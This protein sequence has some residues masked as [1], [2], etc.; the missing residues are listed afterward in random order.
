MKKSL[1]I[2]IIATLLIN[3]LSLVNAQGGTIGVLPPE[4]LI[5]GYIVPRDLTWVVGSTTVSIEAGTTTFRGI[6]YTWPSD[7]GTST[8]V[9]STDGSSLLTWVAQTGGAGGGGTFWS[10]A[11]TTMSPT[12][13]IDEINLTTTTVLGDN[14]NFYF[15]TSKTK[16]MFSDNTGDYDG[17]LVFVAPGE[18]YFSFLETWTFY[19]NAS[20]TWL[21]AIDLGETDVGVIRL[22]SATGTKIADGWAAGDAAL[23][24]VDNIATTDKTFQFPNYSGTLI[25]TGNLSDINEVGTISTG[26]WQGT[27]IADAYISNTLTVTGYMQDEDINTFNELQAW[28]T[29]EVV[30]AS[31]SIDTFNELNIIVTDKTLVNEEDAI[32]FDSAIL[33]LGAVTI[34]SYIKLG[35]AKELEFGSGLDYS[36]GYVAADDAVKF[37]L[38]ADCTSNTLWSFS[39]TTFAINTGLTLDTDWTGIL[40]ADSGVVSTTTAGAGTVTSVAMSVPTGLAIS[41]SPITT[42]GTLALTYDTGYSA[43]L[44]ASTTE[45]ANVYAWKSAAIDGSDRLKMAYGGT[46]ADLSAI[47]TGGLMVGNGA[48][49]LAVLNLGTDHYVLVASSTASEGMVW[50]KIDISDSTNLTASDG[51]TLTG[52][53]LTADLGTEIDISSETNLATSTGILLSNDTLS[54][55]VGEIDHDSLLNFVAGEHFLQSAITEV[56]TIATGTWEATDIG[57]AHGGTGVSSWTQY[58]LVYADAADSLSQIAIGSD[59]QVL[60]SGGAGSAPSFA[61]LSIAAGEYAAGSIDGDDINSNLAGVGL[62]LTAASPDTLDLDTDMR[63]DTKCI[64]IEDPTAADDL[65][66]IWRTTIA[67]TITEIWCESDQTI[68]F[69]LQEDDGSPADIIGTDLQCAAGENSTTTFSDAAIAADSRIDLITT[70]VANTPTWVSICWTYTIDD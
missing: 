39:S 55:V 69:D 11:G 60:T 10:I 27:A 30:L 9:L 12:T 50:Q 20:T 13:T 28:V 2:L 61:T 38:G 70:S 29:D 49:S 22:V 33:M 6:T 48:G 64:Y 51:V 35:D 32:T 47:T 68:D 52:D 42:S 19:A 34:D 63:T 23:L 3:G 14:I 57:V 67:I 8:Y 43:I 31:S 5:S 40:R 18:E 4:R 26:T 59:G 62:T 41:G 66:S 53:N 15:D 44:D 36:M 46:E 58:L 16:Y 45:W 24:R 25:A 37:A 7:V 56:G 21:P 17:A 54:V 65:T 1:I